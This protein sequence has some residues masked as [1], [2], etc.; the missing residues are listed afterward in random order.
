MEIIEP[1]AILELNCHGNNRV[2]NDLGSSNVMEIMEP[3]A[4]LGAQMVW[5]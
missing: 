5:K 4:I 3:A 2:C 1:A